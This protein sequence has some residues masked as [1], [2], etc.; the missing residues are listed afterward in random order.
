MLQSP[1]LTARNYRLRAYD[2]KAGHDIRFVMVYRRRADPWPSLEPAPSGGRLI[3]EVRR[4]G[5][6]LAAVYEL[7][8]RAE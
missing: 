5:V 2:D 7:E 6:Q 8:S 4:D 3:S 1:I